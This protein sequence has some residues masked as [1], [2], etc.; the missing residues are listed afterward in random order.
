MIHFNFVY[1]TFFLYLKY[2]CCHDFHAQ[3]TTSP[4]TTN[5]T[6]QP[7]NVP[8]GSVSNLICVLVHC[9]TVYLCRLTYP[10][11]I[12]IQ[13]TSNPTN[14]PSSQPTSTANPTANVSSSS[15]LGIYHF[16][17]L[18][19]QF[20]SHMYSFALILFSRFNI[21]AHHS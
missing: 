7:T 11:F 6:A 14:Q 2:V 17:S 1:S 5:P 4:P 12:N 9:H 8:S 21:A 15:L 18:Y 16:V 19:H 10:L 13:P 20:T 3:P